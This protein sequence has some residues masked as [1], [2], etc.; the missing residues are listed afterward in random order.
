MVDLEVRRDQNGNEFYY[1][2]V[3]FSLPDDS[4]TRVTSS[5]GSWPPAYEKGALVTVR[6]DPGPPLAARISSLS[7]NI[8]QWTV[9]IITGVLGLAFAGATVFARWVLKAEPDTDT[10]EEK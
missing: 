5:E 1:P 4:L 3:E 10:P 6:Y 8:G 7:G 2:V 9:T